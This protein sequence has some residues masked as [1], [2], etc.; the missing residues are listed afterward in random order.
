MFP[1]ATLRGMR[2]YRSHSGIAPIITDWS[3]LSEVFS[4]SSVILCRELHAKRG[5]DTPVM[6]SLRLYLLLKDGTGC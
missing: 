2:S 6:R 5:V 4:L 1:D 3:L